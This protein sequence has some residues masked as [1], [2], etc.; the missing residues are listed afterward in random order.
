MSGRAHLKIAL[1][2][3]L[4]RRRSMNY[5]K[6]TRKQLIEAIKSLQ[7]E[8]NLNGSAG[9]S[10]NG[11]GG[12][13]RLLHAER[14]KIEQRFRNLFKE[15]PIL[16][17]TTRNQ[18]GAPVV[19]GCNQM[20]LQSLGYNLVEVMEKPL[21][22]FYAPKYRHD[23]LE[24]GYQRA[25]A[26]EIST[27]ECRL[28]TKKGNIMHTL[29][30]AIPEKDDSESETIGTRAMYIDITGQKE[31][32]TL[33]QE[34]AD[35]IRALEAEQQRL[36]KEAEALKEQAKAAQK[37]SE[38]DIARA[39]EDWQKLEG[40]LQ[41]EIEQLKSTLAES[42]DE[43][44]KV[45]EE[46]QKRFE[47]QQTQLDSS[48]QELQSL[49]QQKENEL[50]QIRSNTQN[51]LQQKEADLSFLSDSGPFLVRIED[52]MQQTTYLSESWIDF[53]DESEES[54]L[55]RGWFNYLH[56]TDKE[57][58][59]NLLDE[60]FINQAEVQTEFR[61]SY[62]GEEFRWVL[63]HG[64][65]RFNSIGEF[66]G[67]TYTL[68]DIHQRKLEELEVRESERKMAQLVLQSPIAIVE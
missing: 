45:R 40:G 41:E 62:Q 68:L 37:K 14:R 26:G 51:L 12:M 67:F 25:L 61:L 22:D 65:P 46:G 17:V 43:L 44:E 35:N 64:E 39:K 10:G 28:V 38:A 8:E 31:A 4:F 60:G 20:F 47:E 19:T 63:C 52:K 58:I 42:S 53:V 57:P 15:T 49:L 27:E 55:H 54:L 11:N 9:I 6:M 32:E 34:R 18:D 66:E 24:S 56:P 3:K 50:E 16:Y 59:S 23:L 29:M 1:G 30:R 21:S 7:S 36:L 2:E 48:L 5:S 33:L 13:E